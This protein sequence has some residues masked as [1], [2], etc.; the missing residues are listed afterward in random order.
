MNSGRVLAAAAACIA[1]AAAATTYYLFDPAEAAWMPHCLWKTLTGT[2]CPG[3][4]SQ[5]MMHALMHGDLARAWHAN[6]FALCMIPFIIFL[7]WLEMTRERHPE[8]YARLHKTSTIWTLAG[9]ITAWWIC[10]N[11]F[12]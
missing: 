8:L 10:R 11:L 6:A 7:L 2:D 5:R 12:M 3:C 4:G 9:V 1:I